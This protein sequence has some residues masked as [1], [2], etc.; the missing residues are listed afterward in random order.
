MP[1]FGLRTCVW[2]WDL[3]LA[4][5]CFQRET[6]PSCVSDLSPFLL[7][8]LLSPF[9]TPDSLGW[10]DPLLS[11][12]YGSYVMAVKEASFSIK[13]EIIGFRRAF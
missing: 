1:A 7:E 9:L 5:L 10:D 3:Q 11:I 4:Y 2:V 6:S 13:G 8:N 12:K